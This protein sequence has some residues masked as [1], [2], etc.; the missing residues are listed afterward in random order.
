MQE[1]GSGSGSAV[2]QSEQ[3]QERLHVACMVHTHVTTHIVGVA[4]LHYD[5]ITSTARTRS[6][7]EWGHCTLLRVFLHPPWM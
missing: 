3:R 4:S 1:S 7:G 2:Q 5:T 6:S